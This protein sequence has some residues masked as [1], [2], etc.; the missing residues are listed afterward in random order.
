MR[1]GY[2][3][4][5]LRLVCGGDLDLLLV[6]ADTRASV[7]DAIG[8]PSGTGV[9]ED[10]SWFYMQSTV[11]TMAYQAPEITDRQVLVVDFDQNGVLKDISR[12]GLEDGRVINLQ[13]R[14]TPTDNQRVSVLAR[15]LGNV[16]SIGPQLPA[17]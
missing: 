3:L 12:F 1:V 8:T 15:L 2:G 6:G 9:T 11:E 17:P 16:G 5:I 10:S 4:S 14:V 7:A 13:T